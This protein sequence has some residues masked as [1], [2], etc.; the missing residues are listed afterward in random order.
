MSKVIPGFLS[1]A[2]LAIQIGG[3][4][5]AYAT[6]LTMSDRMTTAPVGGIGSYNA[7]AIEPLQYSVNGSFAVTIY[8]TAAWM[9]LNSLE[10]SNKYIPDRAT[11]HTERTG[12]RGNSFLNKNSFSPMHLMI[13]RTFD[14]DVYERYPTTSGIAEYVN[15]PTYKIHDCRL[16]SYSIA[17]APGSILQ[18]N[19]GFIGMKMTDVMASVTN[20]A[21]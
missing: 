16:T 4:R 20:A 2:K 11:A 21:E 12:A 6:S 3:F 18:E 7:D 9:A 17:F 15:K 1:S 13:S 8:D 14:I 5:V 19:I 10:A